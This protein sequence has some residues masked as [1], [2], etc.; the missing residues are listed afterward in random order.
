M[1]KTILP[2]KQLDE[3]MIKILSSYKPLYLVIHCNHPDEI[4]E[5]VSSKLNILADNGIVLLSQSALL[6]G[7]NNSSEILEKLFKKL[8]ENR[9][10]PY[11]LHH[12]DLVPGTYHFR[13]SIKEGQEILKEL[14][15][16]FLEF[17]GLHMS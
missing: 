9:V 17:A 5:K 6:K 7:I 2:L 4:T 3:E 1:W 14:E 15:E 10:K 11:Y 12:C 8:I 13:T 16:E